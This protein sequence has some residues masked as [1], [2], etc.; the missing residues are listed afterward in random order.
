[1][2]IKIPDSIMPLER[3]EKYEDPLDAF[4][5][6]KGL[7]EVTGGGTQLLK[8]NAAGERAI[9][10]VGVDVDVY[11]PDNAIPLLIEKLKE[12][13][14]PDGTVI[15]QYEPVERTIDVK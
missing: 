1:M 7:G 15:E 8:A 6:E 5:K 13:G 10:W 4:L 9:E 14:V 11:N 3:G 12:L 2:F